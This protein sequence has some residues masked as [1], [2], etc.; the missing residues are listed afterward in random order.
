MPPR[1]RTKTAAP[2]LPVPQSDEEAAAAIARIGELHRAIERIKSAADDQVAA[3]AELA[4]NEAAPLRAQHAAAIEGLKTYCEA[5]R[6]RLTEGGKTK[7]AKFLTGVV[8]WRAR[9]PAVRLPR[10]RE[11][12][13]DLIARLK[14]LGLDRFIRT[15]EEVDKE[16]ML[17]EPDVAASVQ[18][19]S[20]GSAGEDFVVEPLEL[21]GAS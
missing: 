6:M 13:A 16:A 5:H 20:I 3:I 7:T 11:A 2:A 17:A 8:A 18:G 10:A 12:L 19:V 1:A 15:K 9:P 4:A 21:E 14:A